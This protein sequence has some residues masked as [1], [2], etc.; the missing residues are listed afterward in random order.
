MHEIEGITPAAL[1]TTLGVLLS[2][3]GIYLVIDKVVTSVQNRITQR[4]LN[5]AGPQAKLAEEISAKILQSIEPRFEDIDRKLSADKLRIDEHDRKLVT[6]SEQI[7]GMKSDNTMMLKSI[8]AMMMHEITGNGIDS[9][10]E[11]KTE[12]DRYLSGR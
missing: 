8:N 11:H 6:V 12:M 3:C 4:R 1:W 10:K 2:L 9:L 7:K 5:Q